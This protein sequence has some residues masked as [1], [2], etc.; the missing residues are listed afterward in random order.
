MAKFFIHRPI[1]AI[2]ISL[3]IVL[4]GVLAGIQLPIAQYPQISP[5]TVSV[6]T[7]YTGA[8]A[9]VV[10]QTVAQVIEDQV[11]GTQGM[12]YM[13]S[14]SDDTGRYSLQVVFEVGT[15]GDMDS[16]KV[17]NNVAVA[18]PSLPSSV[19]NVGVTTRKASNDMAMMLSMYSVDGT[20]DR[21]F[22][23]NY[24]DI[25]FMDEVK[26]VNGVG[27][28]NIFGSDYSMRV[29]LNPDKLAAVDLTVGQVVSAINEQNQQAAAGTIGAMPLA[30]GQEK[31]YTG[32]LQGRL[33]TIE[34]F[35]NIV[36]K[37]DGEGGFVRLK[38]VARIET[39]QKQYNIISK[40]N[41]N[42]AIGFGIQLT[43]DANAM[44]TVAEVKKIIER[45][46]AKL[47]PGLEVAQEA[48]I[49]VVIVIFV[50]L[51]SWRATIIPLLAVP[52]SLIGTFAAFTLLGFS[53][54]TLTLFAMVLAI[55]LVVDDAI[56]VIEN[57]EKHMEEGLEPVDATERAMDE[58]Q[59]PVVA[60]F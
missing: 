14:N 29:W 18:N 36:L 37:S 35:G 20:Y 30:Q 24:A 19:Q 4:V 50:F 40:F 34:E 57:V 10:N 1:F 58:V 7:S 39:G 22:M 25:Y 52:V 23:K 38:D 12:D 54:N 16:V 33:T 60:H 59:G 44:T 15:D 55:G 28:V 9:E 5:P 6:G 48:L 11:N 8:N 27:D 31:Q 49:L 51:Q 42:P 17:Q 45:E 56:V 3:I 13:S 32:K 46:K 43:S 47:P 21:A 26:R 41:G 53:I 2:V